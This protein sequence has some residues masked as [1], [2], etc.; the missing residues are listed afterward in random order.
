MSVDYKTIER[1][2][3]E[4]AEDDPETS[5][6]CHKDLPANGVARSLLSKT[7]SKVGDIS[8]DGTTCYTQ[9]DVAGG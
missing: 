9:S 1:S 6:K 4:V 3:V 8:F 7:L 2:C 5:N